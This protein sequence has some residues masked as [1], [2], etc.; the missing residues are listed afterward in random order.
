[1]NIGTIIE[2][3]SKF[4]KNHAYKTLGFLSYPLVFFLI[5][6]Y[7]ITYV[8]P[9]GWLVMGSVLLLYAVGFITFILFFIFNIIAFSTINKSANSRTNILA[10]IGYFSCCLS[11]IFVII[12]SLIINPGKNNAFEKTETN[13][14]ADKILLQR[15]L[16]DVNREN[17]EKYNNPHYNQSLLCTNSRENFINCFTKYIDNNYDIKYVV[18]DKNYKKDTNP[19]IIT[20]NKSY[21]FDCFYEYKD[22]DYFNYSK[23]T[24]SLCHVWI[25][26]NYGLYKPK[27]LLTFKTDY[28]LSESAR[29]HSDFIYEILK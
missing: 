10:D 26:Y 14:E 21:Y 18:K 12:G 7:D 5:H 29:K 11:I 4:R 20:N 1:M 24:P 8:H 16:D 3:L 28:F 22:K 2:N 13:F 23:A 25:T 15:F 17:K 6:L 27:H 9:C 19:K